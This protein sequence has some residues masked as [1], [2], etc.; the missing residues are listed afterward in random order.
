MEVKLI[1][2]LA[3]REIR[4]ALESRGIHAPLEELMKHASFTF[5]ISGVSRALTHQL[6]RHRMASYTQQSQRYVK[7]EDLAETAVK[8]KTVDGDAESLFRGVMEHIQDAYGRLL[9]AG[10]PEEDARFILPN[11]A[12]TNI[13]VTMTAKHLLHFFG[14]RCCNRAQWE[15]RELADRML[16]LVRSVD[17]EAFRKAGPNCYQLG[18]C[19]EGSFSCG[20][21]E[22]MREKYARL[23]YE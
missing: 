20:R 16:K 12:P 6:V 23:G 9:S 19:P 17:P 8:P 7:V 3:P 4:A 1:G 13:I 21:M 5:S 10:V 2:Y 18:Y 22:E 11:A 15:I 14:L